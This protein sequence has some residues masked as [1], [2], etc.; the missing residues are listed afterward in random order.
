MHEHTLKYDYLVIALG[1]E[2]NFFGNSDIEENAFTMKTIDDAIDL[3]NH[4]IKILEQAN[5]EQDNHELRKKLVNF[6]SCWRG[7]QWC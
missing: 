7:I 3:R 6:C 2:N 5:L 4:I 1:S